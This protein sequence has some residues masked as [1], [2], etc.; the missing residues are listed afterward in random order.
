[1]HR[2]RKRNNARTAR[3]VAVAANAERPQILFAQIE[4]AHDAR[5]Q[6]QDDVG[7]EA[8]FAGVGTETTH[9]RQSART[10]RAVSVRTMSLA[11]LSL[12]LW[13]KRR[14]TSGR[15]LSPMIPESTRRSSSRMRPAS[16]L[17]SPSCRRITM[18]A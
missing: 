1:L 2:Q 14:P 4:H 16:M 8:L 18:R 11:R 10:M 15:S 12:R 17:V 3:D 6:R 13:A 7:L 9:E 5:R